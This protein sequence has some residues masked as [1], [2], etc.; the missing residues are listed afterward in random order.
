M[1]QKLKDLILESTCYIDTSEGVVD[2]SEEVMYSFDGAI[3]TN[4]P[5]TSNSWGLRLI[6]NLSIIEIT[7]NTNGER[8]EIQI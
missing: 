1:Q 8:F 5:P 4:S 2:F 3:W 7:D 6:S